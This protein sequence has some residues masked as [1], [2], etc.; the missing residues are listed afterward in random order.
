MEVRKNTTTRSNKH[1]STQDNKEEERSSQIF[2]DHRIGELL[3]DA[4]M[5]TNAFS[6]FEDT[7]QSLN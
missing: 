4:I 7:V 5:V 3:K 2:L 6:S 1:I